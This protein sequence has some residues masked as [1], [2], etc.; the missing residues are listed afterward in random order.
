M[1]QLTKTEALFIEEVLQEML[2]SMESKEMI[3]STQEIEEALEIIR[4][5]NVYSE[6]EMLVLEE[7]E[8]TEGEVDEEYF[9]NQ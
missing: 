6:E 1:I 7:E 4:A 5:C 3:E 8:Y 2:Y 9:N